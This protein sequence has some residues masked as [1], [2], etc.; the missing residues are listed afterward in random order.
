LILFPGVKSNYKKN[1][2]GNG[3][4]GNDFLYVRFEPRPESEKNG[5]LHLIWLHNVASNLPV[6]FKKRKS[7][8][9][10]QLRKNA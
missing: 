5:R 8:I 4:T 10:F 6:G 9:N 3:R 1:N 2:C 7:E